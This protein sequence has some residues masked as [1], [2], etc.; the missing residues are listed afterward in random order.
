MS[1][2]KSGKRYILLLFMLL[3]PLAMLVGF[4]IW[5]VTENVEIKPELGIEN[6]IIKYLDNNE[7]IYDGNIQLPSNTY[8]G[9]DN[10]LTYYYKGSSDDDYIAVDL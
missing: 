6:V 5:I 2:K 1:A 10:E 4:S 8:L 7:T 3:I 9:L